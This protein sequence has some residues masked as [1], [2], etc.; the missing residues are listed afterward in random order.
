MARKRYLE[1]IAITFGVPSVFY[2]TNIMKDIGMPLIKNVEFVA[3][4][5]GNVVVDT[6]R[7]IYWTR[8][9]GYRLVN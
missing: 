6:C 7:F 3:R 2:V 1:M 9:V 4:P 5:E 8:W